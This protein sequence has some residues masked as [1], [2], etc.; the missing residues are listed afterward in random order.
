MSDKEGPRRPSRFRR[1]I[2][3]FRTSPGE[4]EATE[5][6]L[7]E[8][9]V[10]GLIDKDESEMMQGILYL[11]K[12]TVR[13]VMVPR[14]EIVFVDRKAPLG[15][16]VQTFVDA[17]HTRLVVVDDDLDHVVG[18]VNV[19]DVLRFCNQDAQFKLD[20]ILRRVYIVPETKKLD[21][22][23]ASLQERREHFALVIDEFGGTSGLVSVED[24]LEEIVGEIEDEHDREEPQILARE[25]NAVTITGRFE[26]YKLGELLE[27]EEPEGSFNTVGGWIMDRIGRMPLAGEK[28]VLDGL[29]V[30]VEAATER[31]I[32]RVRVA[33]R[34]VVEGNE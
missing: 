30:M 16:I 29:D 7:T 32:R 19:I 26:M 6:A 28:F 12:T 5:E 17:G 18:Y 34:L 33:R 3:L 1:F 13:E 24:I 21:D 11:D 31:Q 8:L 23:L 9:Q 14:T 20:P 2:A 4:D 15:E 10:G 27:V 22:L 25:E